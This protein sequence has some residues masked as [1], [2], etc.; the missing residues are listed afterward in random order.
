MA[1]EKSDVIFQS[2]M[3][4]QRQRE[5]YKKVLRAEELRLM[6]YV[7]IW[8]ELLKNKKNQK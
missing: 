1:R 3:R 4:I 8:L 2:V 7:H 5:D 6:M